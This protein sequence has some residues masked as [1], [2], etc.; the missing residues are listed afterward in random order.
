MQYSWL[1]ARNEGIRDN[2]GTAPFFIVGTT[3]RRVDISTLRPLFPPGERSPSTHTTRDSKGTCNGFEG[4]EKIPL[5]LLGIEKFRRRPA[6]R[7]ITTLTE[8]PKVL[9]NTKTDSKN[10]IKI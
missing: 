10:E 1:C 4:S 9:R 6:R 7:L 2:R 5:S 3:R 8:L